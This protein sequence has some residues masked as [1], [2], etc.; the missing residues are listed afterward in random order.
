[1]GDLI[2]DF[3]EDLNPTYVKEYH[4]SNVSSGFSFPSPWSAVISD[5]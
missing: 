4:L 5:K 2:E 3:I 1:M